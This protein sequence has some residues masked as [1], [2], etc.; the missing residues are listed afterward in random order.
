MEADGWPHERIHS[1]A[2]RYIRTY[3]EKESEWRF[4]VLDALA[5]RLSRIVQLDADERA[6]VTCFI[7][8]QHWY[9]MT[10]ARIFGV[11]QGSRFDCSPLDVRQWR[12]GD[13][14]HS[15]RSE[16]ELATLGLAN[17]AHARFSY[18]T[19]P[20]APGPIYYERFWTLKYPVLEKLE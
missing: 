7:D 1:V 14:K 3:T 6:I 17:G 16:V 20:A 2:L 5:Q 18:E 8:A 19:G 13:F 4:T 12:W 11:F 15:G 9:A 10:T